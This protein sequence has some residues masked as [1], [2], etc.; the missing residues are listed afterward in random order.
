MI[1]PASYANGFAPRDGMPLYPELWRG[2]VGAWNPGLGPTGLTL[3]DWSGFGNHCTLTNMDPG[4]DWVTSQGRY[5]LDFDGVNDRASTIDWK[6]QPL[7]NVNVSFGA[8][9]IFN[10]AAS[11]LRIFAGFGTDAIGG[12][13]GYYLYRTSTGFPICEF[14]SGM[15]A[16]TGSSVLAIGQEYHFC[17]TYDGATNRLYVDG[18]QVASAAFSTA[19]LTGSNFFI[20]CINAFGTGPSYFEN[21]K[22]QEA[23]VW[24]RTLSP[25]EIRILASRRGIAYELAPRR[26]SSSAVQFNRRRRLLVGAGS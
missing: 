5:A 22:I 10:S 14:G 17:G 4:T 24:A 16:A 26:R 12:R 19:N 1:L 6:S 13:Q 23:S 20:G 15:G 18:V 2:C 9:V 21:C 8:R 3:R 11:G 7:G 25:N